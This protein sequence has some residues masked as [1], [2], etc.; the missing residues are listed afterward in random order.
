MRTF[1]IWLLSSLFLFAFSLLFPARTRS[2]WFRLLPGVSLILALI[3]IFL[4]GHRWQMIPIYTYAGLLFALT[5]KNLRFAVN[6]SHKSTGIDRLLARIVRG[7]LNLLLLVL[8]SMPPLLVPVF[9]LPL[10]TGPY[11]VGI[12]YDYLVDRNRSEPLTSDPA[13]FQEISVQVRYP[14]EISKNDAPVKY[15][16]N[17][18]EKSRII[19]AF[20]GG[21]PPFLFNHFFLIRTHSYLNARLARGEQAF[22]VLIFNH[23]FLGL[24]SLNTVLTEELASHGFIVFSIGHS[25]STPF[26]TRPDGSIKAFDP[27]NEDLQRRMQENDDPEVREIADRLMQSRDTEEQETLL[28]QFLA[29][30]PR[31]QQSLFRWARDISFALD[32]MERLNS[33]NGF[34][35]GKLDLDR[36]GVFGVSF[37]GAASTQA[38][39]QEKRCKAAIS[40]DCP[41]FGDFLD[42]DVSQPIVFMSSEQY[43]DMNDIFLKIKENPL[44]SVMIKNTTHQNLSDISIWGKL[45]KMQMLGKIDGERCLNV[46]NRYILAFF[47]K[48]L[49]GIDDGF[50][51][52]PSPE[53]PEVEFISRN[54]D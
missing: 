20:W 25:D 30:N 51:D 7:A 37:G 8:I 6:S 19:S 23:G 29:K 46:Q 16:E 27:N 33:G 26:F 42:R 2:R 48:Y 45:F 49:K 10:P 3:H 18:T 24:P 39:V 52:G 38:C 15:W 11:E 53:Y 32:E 44:Y 5:V 12:K 54:T 50:L 43:K 4:E 13:D 22:P 21:L 14:A 31:N 9:K 17:A 47:E 36:I 34:F 40:I 41:Q 35:S 1:E 28:R